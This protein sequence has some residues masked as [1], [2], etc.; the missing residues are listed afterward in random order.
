M[1]SKN[2]LI[3][4][5]SLFAAAILAIKKFRKSDSKKPVMKR[6][7]IQ[8]MVNEYRKNQLAAI[9]NE[10]KINDTESVWFELDKL[11]Q[12]IAA[13][14]TEAKKA[15]PGIKTSK[16]GIRFYNAAYPE[17]I[18][19]L[20]S[21][22]SIPKNYKGKHTLVMV[23]TVNRKGDH[24]EL[25]YDFNPYNVTQNQSK[26]SETIAVKAAN[27]S[28]AENHGYLIPPRRSEGQSY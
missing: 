22:K 16:L 4:L 7:T 6:D 26:E 25:D 1:K 2:T 10:M 11:K 15:Y 19:E 8:A 12:F 20:F 14:E 21:Y 9:K 3:A 24:G 23:P 13:V 17:N 5:G 27:E 18:E 28:M